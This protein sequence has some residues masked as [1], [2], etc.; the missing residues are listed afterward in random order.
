MKND[1]NTT[2]STR[3]FS[4]FKLIRKFIASQHINASTYRCFG[5]YHIKLNDLDRTAAEDLL[6]RLVNRL[7]LVP[8]T[9][10]AAA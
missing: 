4:M 3:S 2:L 9:L 6:S 10:A 1:S 7:N 8:A 5:T